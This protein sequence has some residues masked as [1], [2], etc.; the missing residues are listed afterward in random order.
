MHIHVLML[1]VKFEL[2]PIKIQFFTNIYSCPKIGL[3]TLYYNTGS[4]AKFHQKLKFENSP[5]LYFF[6][7][8]IHVLMLNIK[9]ELNPINIEIF[10]NF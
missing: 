1:N 10:T 3:K 9:F 2:F 6:L 8:H 7:M 4:L 5:F